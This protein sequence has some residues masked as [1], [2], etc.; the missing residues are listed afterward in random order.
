MC[1]LGE[2]AGGLSFAL[3]S[4]EQEEQRKRAEER[5]GESEARYRRLAE[6]A[7]DFIY[8]YDLFPSPHCS[9]ASPAITRIA[10]YT[11]EEIY[12]DP[13]TLWK[14]VRPED[15]HRLECS[16]ADPGSWQQRE[17]EMAAQGWPHHLG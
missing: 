12:A 17:G 1:L 7:P 15:R 3:E 8:R 10:G 13:D 5:L 11:P 16:A 9:F 2:L 14:T 4:L 6:N